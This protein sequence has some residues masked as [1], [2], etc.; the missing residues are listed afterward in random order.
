ME[1]RLNELKRGRAGNFQSCS[2][3]V[4][5]PLHLWPKS[6]QELRQERGWRWKLEVIGQAGYVEQLLKN[7]QTHDEATQGISPTEA[8]EA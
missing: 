1:A 4:T 5:Q 7:G 2:F 6:A 8:V 3:V